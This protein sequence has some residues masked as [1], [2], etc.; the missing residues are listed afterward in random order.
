V[1]NLKDKMRHI[2]FIFALTLGLVACN[3]VKPVDK[4]EISSDSIKT[5][6]STSQTDFITNKSVD[7]VAIG[8][9]VTDFLS[10]ISK[11][12]TV[13]K[14]QMQLEG[15][16]YDIYNVYDKG[17]KIYSVEPDF[18]KSDIIDRIWIYGKTFKTDKGIGVGSTLA[19]IKSTYHI[20]SIGTE[21]EGGLQILVKEIPVAFIMDNSQLP[22][23]WWEKENKEAIPEDLQVEEIIID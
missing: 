11:Q 22:K 6:I 21:G 5:T 23:D 10:V 20:E 17:Q 2:N 3:N 15:D 19:A 12:Y 14:E 7:G 8:D 13:K 1:Y 4:T 18:D 16:S 9:K